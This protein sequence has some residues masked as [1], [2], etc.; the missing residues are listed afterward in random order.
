[1]IFRCSSLPVLMTQPRGKKDK[2]AGNLGQT[3]KSAVQE[4]VKEELF[5]Y[6]NIITD[7]KLT[8]GTEGEDDSIQ[9]LN[10]VMFSNYKKNT[11]R[12]TNDFITGECD[13][14]AITEIIDIKTSWSKKTFPAAPRNIDLKLYEW[15]L[16]GYMWLWDRPKA[17]LCYALI[18]TP[19]HLRGD[20]DRDDMHD[21]EHIEDP[22][23]IT[24]L[25]I[26]RDLEKEKMIQDQVV[27][28][29]DY[30]KEYRHEILIKSEAYA[31]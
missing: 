31:A 25:S 14:D 2:E 3:A 8:K 24:M 6:K 13:I 20:Y 7:K 1:M 23:R 22:L 10:N 12:K 16:R 21:V 15:Q 27:R 19:H 28:L 26:D 11:E 9:L 30:A 18:N 17:T 5:K 4:L 29:R